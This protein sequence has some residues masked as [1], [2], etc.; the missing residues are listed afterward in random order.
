[1]VGSVATMRVSSVI[2]VPSSVS[3]TLKSTRMKTRLL[4]SSIS[5]MESLG[6]MCLP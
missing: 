4:A 5:R 1:M 3:G 6:M 2:V